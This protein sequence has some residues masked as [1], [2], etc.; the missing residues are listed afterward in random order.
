MTFACSYVV[1]FPLFL[2]NSLQRLVA[3]YRDHSV[4]PIL[5]NLYDYHSFIR[6]LL[7][8]QV[9]WCH[10]FSQ[11]LSWPCGPIHL[12]GF[13][14][15]CHQRHSMTGCISIMK[16]PVFTRKQIPSTLKHIGFQKCYTLVHSSKICNLSMSFDNMHS[17]NES[18]PPKILNLSFSQKP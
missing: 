2:I 16:C 7:W 8:Q 1:R 14:P 13:H 11:R 5:D 6:R 9:C 10:K 18:K 17:S 4:M 12:A 15:L 3:C